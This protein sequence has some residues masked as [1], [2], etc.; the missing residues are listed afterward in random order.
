MD[1][2]GLGPSTAALNLW[3]IQ[4]KYQH[5]TAKALIQKNKDY[6]ACINDLAGH[7][8]TDKDDM[9]VFVFI[10]IPKFDGP[11]KAPW[12]F[13]LR[14]F[15]L[16]AI[17]TPYTVYK[18]FRSRVQ[19]SVPQPRQCFVKGWLELNTNGKSGMY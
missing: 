7:N 8:R 10:A 5:A 6:L 11:H 16:E 17:L 13:Q 4:H 19:S 12:Q 2:R 1:K 18:T 14:Q 3:Y 15:S 9:H